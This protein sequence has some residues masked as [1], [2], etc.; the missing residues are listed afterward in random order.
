MTPHTKQN[1]SVGFGEVAKSKTFYRELTVAICADTVLMLEKLLLET[2]PLTLVPTS[3]L[4]SFGHEIS[5]RTKLAAVIGSLQPLPKS[6]KGGRPSFS[7]L[8]LPITTANQ[9]F[10]TFPKQRCVES[11]GPVGGSNQTGGSQPPARSLTPSI[12]HTTGVETPYKPVRAYLLRQTDYGVD[13]SAGL[14]TLCTGHG[15]CR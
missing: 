5:L 14:V 1:V 3:R 6:S 12:A 9:V 15:C 8:H 2:L 11:P 10:P 4:Y 7:C 13:H